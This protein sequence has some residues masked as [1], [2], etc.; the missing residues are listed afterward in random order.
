MPRLLHAR[1]PAA[2]NAA[3]LDCKVV[4]E[5]ANAPVMPD[6]DKVRCSYCCFHLCFSLICPPLS[7]ARCPR[8]AGAAPHCCPVTALSGL[9]LTGGIVWRTHHAFDSACGACGTLA[10]C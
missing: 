3:K 2:A 5:A 4:V 8:A 10:A 9:V 7:S 1:A 6:G